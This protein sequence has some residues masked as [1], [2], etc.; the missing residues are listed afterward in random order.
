MAMVYRRVLQT[1]Y[2]KKLGD[3]KLEL[4]KDSNEVDRSVLD[5]VKVSKTETVSMVE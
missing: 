1:L 2:T 3:G 4:I 5:P